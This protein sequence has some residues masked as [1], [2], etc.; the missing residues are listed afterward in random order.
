MQRNFIMPAIFIM[1]LG[2]SVGIGIAQ[3]TAINPNPEPQ[4]EIIDENK[5]ITAEAEL[6]P[7]NGSD[8]TGHVRFVQTETGVQVQYHVEGLGKMSNHGFHIHEVGDCSS[9][10]AK[11]AG[12]H[13]LPIA[14]T[15]GTSSDSPEKHLGDLPQ[16][17]SDITG[18]ADGYFS[19]EGLSINEKNPILGRAVIVHG[20]PDNPELP[21]PPRIACGVIR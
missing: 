14:P 6:G 3:T 1:L 18:I 13:Y 20:G 16:I 12:A 10:D 11:S 4:A 19:V 7:R 17:T 2:I 21:S 9:P 15:G 8:V 5:A